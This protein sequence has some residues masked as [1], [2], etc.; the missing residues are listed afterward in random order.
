MDVPSTGRVEYLVKLLHQ[1]AILACARRFDDS[2][3][4]IVHQMSFTGSVLDDLPMLQH[5]S[6]PFHR[7]FDSLLVFR[8]RVAKTAR[9]VRL[10]ERL[11]RFQ[12]RDRLLN[13]CGR[14]VIPF[15]TA[16]ILSCRGHP[17][18]MHFVVHSPDGV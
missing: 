16:Y 11:A 7:L 13:E 15:G 8:D 12:I 9:V 5:G 2:Q 1:F 17:A 4:D 18:L 3:N 14:M 10:I 6:E